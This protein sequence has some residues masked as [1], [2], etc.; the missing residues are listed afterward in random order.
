[1]IIVLL[2]EQP[3]LSG[4]RL[5]IRFFQNGYNNLLNYKSI[6]F[7][8]VKSLTHVKYILCPSMDLLLTL[9]GKESPN[10]GNGGQTACDPFCLV[11]FT[12][13]LNAVY[14]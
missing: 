8:V 6:S 5:S 11:A 10:T 1:M 12:P 9:A 13:V 3:P 7:S 14:L 2:L 4:F